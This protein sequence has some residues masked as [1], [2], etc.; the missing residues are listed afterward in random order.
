MASLPA[1]TPK[2]VARAKCVARRAGRS[3]TAGPRLSPTPTSARHRRSHRS[4]K[5]V[6]TIDGTGSYDFPLAAIYGR[7]Q[8]QVA[9]GSAEELWAGRVH[10]ACW[11]PQQFGT[12]TA[13]SLEAA[14]F[15]VDAVRIS[16][17][18]SEPTAVLTTTGRATGRVIGGNQD[19]LATSAGWALPD[20]TG[21][22]LLIEGE[23]Q[24]LGHIDRQ[25]TMLMNAGHLRGLRGVAVGQYTRWEPDASAHRNLDC[26]RRAARAHRPAPRADPRWPAHWARPEPARSSDRHGRNHGRRRWHSDRQPGCELTTTDADGNPQLA[27][28][29]RAAG[30][31]GSVW[32]DPSIRFAPVDQVV[33]NQL[34]R[35]S[36]AIRRAP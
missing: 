20:L 1:Q 19:A 36:S 5:G 26:A 17:D 28:R 15:T 22:V 16:A 31:A 32:S 27:G 2:F 9:H 10:G 29:E 3:I 12:S 33:P 4:Y 24:R 25:L 8:A 21:A 34:A 11:P 14:V 30:S 7:S 13:A 35:R 6:G 23:N 18:P